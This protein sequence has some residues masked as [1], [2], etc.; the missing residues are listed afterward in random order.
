[1]WFFLFDYRGEFVWPLSRIIEFHRGWI[2]HGSPRRDAFDVPRP[3]SRR[4]SAF[5]AIQLFRCN[6]SPSSGAADR[7]QS[8]VVEIVE[9][10]E[11]MVAARHPDLVSSTLSIPSIRRPTNLERHRTRRLVPDLNVK[12]TRPFRTSKLSEVIYQR[13]RGGEGKPGAGST[14]DR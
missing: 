8:I 4:A 3:A 9:I 14:S 10:L 6:V 2:E 13:T 11:I 7:R 12:L 1:M 5:S